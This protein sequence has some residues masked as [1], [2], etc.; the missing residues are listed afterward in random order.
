MGVGPA[1]LINLLLWPQLF[2][3]VLYGVCYE[4]V[5]ACTAGLTRAL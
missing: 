2:S 4:N 5:V 3:I 1:S